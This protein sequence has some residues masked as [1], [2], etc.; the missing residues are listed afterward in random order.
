MSYE[1]GMAALNLEMTERIPKTEYMDHDGFILKATGLDTRNAC[2]QS[3]VGPAMARI[4][5]YDYIWNVY[6]MPVT[7]GRTT[8]MGHAV[9]NEADGK[10]NEV[11][12]PF[13]DEEDVLSFNPVEEY[14]IPTKREIAEAFKKH[15]DEGQNSL[16]PNGVY[17]GGRY[18]SLFSACI[19]TFGWEMFLAS[20]PYNYERFDRILEGFYQISYAEI[21]G[22]IEA[23]IKVFNMHD[24]ICW[25]SGAVLHPDWY[26]KYIFPR[27][28][29]LWE[30]LKEAGIKII[31]TSDGTYTEFI[32]DIF[33]A[34]ADGVVLEPTTSLEFV[35][36][37]YGKTKIAIGNMDC[38]ILQY[39]TKEDVYNEVKRCSDLGKK[40]P[41]YFF[42]VGNHI[43]NGI[44]IE[45]IEYY[46]ECCDR[47]G[48][49]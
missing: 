47:L 39:G 44:P 46:F 4:L 49:R 23:G 9:W 14:G 25:T 38:R 28:K 42:A 24:D 11:Y 35:L 43:P 29:K 7:R 15:Y 40:C 13:E 17:P 3:Q 27:Y 32:D 19:R 45:N 2:H 22:W 12:C 1:R 10:D 6:E 8:K 48:R 33:T 37:K 30:P 18:N 20:V 36:E 31:Y 26:R 21:E 16:Y 5:D 41:G 34:G